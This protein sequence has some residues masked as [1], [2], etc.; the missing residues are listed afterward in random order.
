MIYLLGFVFKMVV[1]FFV[2]ENGVIDENY[3]Y[4]CIGKI[5]VGNINE[6]L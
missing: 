5:K 3:I 4:N 6:I 2:F 1:L